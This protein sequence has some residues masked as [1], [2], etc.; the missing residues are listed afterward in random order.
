MLFGAEHARD[1]AEDDSEG[2]D[3]ER[4]LEVVRG[5]LARAVA[6]RLQRGDLLALGPDDARQEHVQEERGDAEEDDGE[7]PI[8]VF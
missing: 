2:A 8:A 4:E 6:E 7:R 1:P 5:K 3:R